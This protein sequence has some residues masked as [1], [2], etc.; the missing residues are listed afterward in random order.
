MLEYMMEMAE[1]GEFENVRDLVDEALGSYESFGEALTE[2]LDFFSGTNGYDN[3]AATL[4]ERMFTD[5]LHK[6]V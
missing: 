5:Y 1:S 3:E 2:L 6:M 4:I